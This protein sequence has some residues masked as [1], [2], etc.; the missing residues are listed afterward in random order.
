M[1]PV[2]AHEIQKWTDGFCTPF[3]KGFH[4]MVQ[5]KTDT[6]TVKVWCVFP[7]THVDYPLNHHPG[8]CD[9]FQRF[10]EDQ[11]WFFILETLL[12]RHDWQGEKKWWEH[13]L[14][15]LVT[16]KI[17][18]TPHISWENLWCPFLM[19]PSNHWQLDCP[20]F[21]LPATGD[22]SPFRSQRAT[23]SETACPDGPEVEAKGDPWW[24]EMIPWG[25]SSI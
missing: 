15:G 17:T 6:C 9:E 25:T 19:F 7:Y 16:G 24:A 14:N 23:L 5:C 10:R 3:P 1:C 4:W 13:I 22:R 20:K 18:G 8:K 12:K 2:Y 21:M 11:T